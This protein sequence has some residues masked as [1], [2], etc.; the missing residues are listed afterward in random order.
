MIPQLLYT[1]AIVGRAAAIWLGVRLSVAALGL[2][3]ATLYLPAGSL[4]SPL[5]VAT[6]LALCL[7]ELHRRGELLLLANL[8]SSAETLLLLSAVPVI[9]LEA[10]STFLI[11]AL[12]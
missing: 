2:P 5:I 9:P 10:A 4:E 12:R 7:L 1:R 8:G 11:L 3:G 6:A